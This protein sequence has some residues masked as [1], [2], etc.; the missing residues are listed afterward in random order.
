MIVER[1]FDG[2]EHWFECHNCGEANAFDLAS[3]YDVI[4]CH[5]CYVD[6]QPPGLTGIIYWVP[7]EVEW[8]REVYPDSS[9]IW[10]AKMLFR[11]YDSVCFKAKT[12]RLRK[13]EAY[14]QRCRETGQYK[15]GNKPANT[16]YD[17]AITIR[18]AERAI[19]EK[20]IRIAEGHW[21]SLSRHTWRQH[22]GEIPK[23]YVVAFIDQDSLNCDINNLELIS[24]AENLRRNRQKYLELPQELRDNIQAVATLRRAITIK[25]KNNAS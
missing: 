5:S 13:S 6:N 21:E 23:G 7:E 22:H 3:G 24:Q 25:L 12:L 19:P 9:N 15:K 8:L 11:S 10:I 16:L 4:S 2:E 1:R 20:Y 18:N 14:S 17:G